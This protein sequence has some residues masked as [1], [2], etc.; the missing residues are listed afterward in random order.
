MHLSSISNLDHAAGHLMAKIDELQY[1][2]TRRSD[3]KMAPQP[4]EFGTFPAGF[5]S[6]AMPVIQQLLA[7][8]HA[9]PPVMRNYFV[10][11]ALRQNN[12]NR[13]SKGFRYLEWPAFIL[14]GLNLRR[15][16]QVL[17][18]RNPTSDS[19][20]SETDE[21]G[22]SGSDDEEQGADA[23]IMVDNQLEDGK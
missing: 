13:R 18:M 15:Y 23:Q 3:A 6:P 1:D 11:F 14:D 19:T 9:K 17:K 2:K 10:D 4:T 21:N 16:D 7:M 22:D 12:D 8:S 5:K 20:D